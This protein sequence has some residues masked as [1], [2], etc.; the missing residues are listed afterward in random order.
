MKLFDD[1]N[2]YLTF[3][4]CLVQS[5]ELVP[6]ALYA[7]CVMPNHFH[8]IVRPAGDSDLTRFMRI[9]TIRHSKRWHIRRQ[10]KGGGAVYQGRFRAFP[11]QTEHYF[12]AACRYVEANPLRANL[13]TRA[14]EWPWSSIGRMERGSE[15]PRLE[16]WPVLRPDHWIDLVNDPQVPREVND[17]RKCVRSNLP[18]GGQSWSHAMATLL[19]TSPSLRKP[20]LRKHRN[21]GS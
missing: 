21:I 10:S 7:F 5:L 13:V 15:M 3:V 11:I 16:P 18:F 19:E 1:R 9:L 4:R 14:E 6:V 8:L 20:G 17:L 12:Y 2:D